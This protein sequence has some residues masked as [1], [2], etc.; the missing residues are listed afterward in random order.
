MSDC[1]DKKDHLWQEDYGNRP[2]IHPPVTNTKIRTAHRRGTECDVF[3][4]EYEF[5][6]CKQ[7]GLYWYTV[8]GTPVEAPIEIEGGKVLFKNGLFFGK[9]ANGLFVKIDA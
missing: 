9:D 6:V 5:Y 8:T 2:R 7:C 4:I 3:H 1:I